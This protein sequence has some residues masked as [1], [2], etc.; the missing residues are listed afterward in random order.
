LAR[1]CS[2]ICSPVG[3]DV[4]DGVVQDSRR[5]HSWL[6]QAFG[7]YPGLF[8]EAFAQGYRLSRAV[9]AA[10]S[11]WAEKACSSS[12]SVSS[13]VCPEPAAARTW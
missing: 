5:F 7:A 13:F 11:R 3:K 9:K 1:P 12:A 8:P 10:W 6:D 2:T 4:Y